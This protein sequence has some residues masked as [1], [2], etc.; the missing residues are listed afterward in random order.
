MSKSVVLGEMG[1]DARET[2]TD[3]QNAG[4]RNLNVRQAANAAIEK[5]SSKPTSP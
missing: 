1:S 2:V 5:M 4:K 3:L